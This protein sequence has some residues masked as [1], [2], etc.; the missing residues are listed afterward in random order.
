M[1]TAKDFQDEN[2]LTDL[3]AYAFYKLENPD[4]P[5]VTERIDCFHIEDGI[6]GHEILFEECDSVERILKHVYHMSEKAWF[7]RKIAR[8]FIPLAMKRINLSV[9]DLFDE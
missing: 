2:G 7:N 8:E 5:L 4:P 6:G 3:R 1:K 9:Q